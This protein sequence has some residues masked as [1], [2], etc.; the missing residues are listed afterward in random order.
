MWPVQTN[1][2]KAVLATS[3]S[4]NHPHSP[5]T[6]LERTM[7]HSECVSPKTSFLKTRILIYSIF[8]YPPFSRNFNFLFFLLISYQTF[9]SLN[10]YLEWLLGFVLI[11]NYYE[12]KTKQKTQTFVEFHSYS[13]RNYSGLIPDLN[14]FSLHFSAY[15]APICWIPNFDPNSLVI[16]P[17]LIPEY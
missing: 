17:H 15:W 11:E 4:L 6:P 9:Y 3:T 10:L 13:P 7:F 14:D 8:T 2:A 1:K 16:K 12:K 5:N